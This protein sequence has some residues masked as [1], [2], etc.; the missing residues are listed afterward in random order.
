M[1]GVIAINWNIICKYYVNINL[2]EIED[3]YVIKYESDVSF[4]YKMAVGWIKRNTK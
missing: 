1:I 3:I 2:D 4:I